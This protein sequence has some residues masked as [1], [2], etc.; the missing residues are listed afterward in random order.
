MRSNN[1][2]GRHL[3]GV[4]EFYGVVLDTSSI[5]SILLLI[6]QYLELPTLGVGGTACHGWLSVRFSSETKPQQPQNIPVLKLRFMTC[7]ENHSF[8]NG[9]MSH[10]CHKGPFSAYRQWCYTPVFREHHCTCCWHSQ[11]LKTYT[12]R[13][14]SNL[15]KVVRHSAI[16]RFQH[17]MS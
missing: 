2:I 14:T 5:P 17:E 9:S 15:T 7:L 13:F 4:L 11:H 6:F 8:C 12:P 10:F 3:K 1:I 16:L